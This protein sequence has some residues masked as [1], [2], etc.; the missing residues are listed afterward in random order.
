MDGVEWGWRDVS[1][2]GAGNCHGNGAEMPLESTNGRRL[3]LEYLLV[4]SCHIGHS[5]GH[6]VDLSEI[7]H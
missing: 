7:R 6:S 5:R 2:R 1:G 3:V 4:S